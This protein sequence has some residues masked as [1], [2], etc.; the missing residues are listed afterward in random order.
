[1]TAWGMRGRG[2]PRRPGPR[3]HRS[4][5]PSP[6]G[7]GARGVAKLELAQLVRPGSAA[8]AGV[9]PADVHATTRPALGSPRS[10]GGRPARLC[11]PRP[12]C[13]P[14][15]RSSGRPAR[16]SRWAARGRVPGQPRHRGSPGRANK[17]VQEQQL[18]HLRAARGSPPRQPWPA[19]AVASGATGG[20]RRRQW[21]AGGSPSGGPAAGR[22]RRRGAAAWSPDGRFAG[23]IAQPPSSSAHASWHGRRC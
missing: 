5:I 15:R 20:G 3:R 1:M 2:R 7:R 18:V 6:A 8:A 17:L 9:G 13:G 19:A 16:R 23:V 4:L 14:A 11:R 12:A 10:G 22:A 21:A